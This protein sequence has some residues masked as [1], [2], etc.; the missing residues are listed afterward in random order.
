[1][2]ALLV[3]CALM[4]TERRRRLVKEWRGKYCVWSRVRDF[5][6]GRPLKK[7]VTYVC[8]CGLCAIETLPVLKYDER[9][10]RDA[11]SYAHCHRKPPWR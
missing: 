3:F 7:V 8:E 11:D 6:E 10:R 9:S 5:V 1:M 4:R 2:V